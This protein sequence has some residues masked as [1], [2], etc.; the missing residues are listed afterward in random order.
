M[1]GVEGAAAGSSPIDEAGTYEVALS[2]TN[3][4][5]TGGYWYGTQHMARTAPEN[6]WTDI[7]LAKSRA[8]ITVTD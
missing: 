1:A 2:S 8:A 7:D 3:S 5:K 6:Y 4:R